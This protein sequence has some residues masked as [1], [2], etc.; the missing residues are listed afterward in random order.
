MKITF[1]LFV[2]MIFCSLK[3]ETKELTGSWKNTSGEVT[4]VLLIKDGYFTSTKFTPSVFLETKGG[5]FTVEGNTIHL[6]QE[7][8]T[9]EKA[10]SINKIPF[11]VQKDALLL[12]KKNFER[13]DDGNTSLAGVWQITG[14]MQDG[15]VRQI[16][17]RGTRKTLKMLTGKRFQWFAIDPDGNKFSGTGGGTYTFENGTYIENIEFFSRDSS[18]IGAS[19]SFEGKLEQGKWHHSGLSSK[20][21]HIYEIWE[22]VKNGN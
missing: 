18:R 5:I 16:H 21:G 15:A 13:V 1:L 20:G 2:S 9:V 8:N 3:N 7:F 11:K 6:N 4:T 14:R 10:L 22:K 12:D 19:L 17:Q